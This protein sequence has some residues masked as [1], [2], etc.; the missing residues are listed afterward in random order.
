MF[1]VERHTRPTTSPQIKL[2]YPGMFH[3]MSIIS[4]IIITWHLIHHSPNSISQLLA[5]YHYMMMWSFPPLLLIFLLLFHLYLLV[6][7][8]TLLKLLL[9]PHYI[10]LLRLSHLLLPFP[11]QKILL[12]PWKIPPFLLTMYPFANLP[13]RLRLLL[14]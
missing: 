14:I 8:L 11:T 13:A 10:L 9:L 2:L 3:F 12:L 1:L 7:L 6:L 4:H 5:L